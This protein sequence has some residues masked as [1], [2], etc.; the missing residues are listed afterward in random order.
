[1]K[2]SF[3]IPAHNEET[4]IKP[5]LESIIK[6]VGS[7]DDCEIVVVN[8]A[9]S[10]R[11]KEIALAFPQV[12][13]V[14][15]P[16][17]GLSQAR[18]TGMENSTGELIANVD[19]DTIMPAGW[20]DKVLS[21]FN[22]DPNLVCL[23]GPQVYFDSSPIIRLAI[24][25]YYGFAYMSYFINSRI[26]RVGALVQGGNFIVRRRAM[27]AIGGI[28]PAF[29]FYGEDVDIARRIFKV[30]KVFF[31][32]RLFI[33]ASGRRV[34]QDGLLKMAFVYPIN[35]FWTIFFGRPFTK[36]YTNVRAGK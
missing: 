17:K 2:L 27:E 23:S 31:T 11:T 21:Y 33:Y 34:N 14:D 8:N 10:D 25:V 5:C 7:R 3:V 13:V 32:L 36:T 18:K 1:M 9:S 24:W 16:R 35:Y 26:L 4:V 22:G 28:N 20:V 6:E 19:A 30:G 29:S 12:R 15:E